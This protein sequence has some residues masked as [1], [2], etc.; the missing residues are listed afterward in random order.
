MVAVDDAQ[1]PELW[2]GL[3]AQWIH[4]LRYPG[5]ARSLFLAPCSLPGCSRGS[6]ARSGLVGH[7]RS[8][9]SVRF[10]LSPITHRD[11]DSR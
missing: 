4:H 2:A 10:W 5:T 3:S 7:G 9:G 1:R 11:I 8:R 6:T